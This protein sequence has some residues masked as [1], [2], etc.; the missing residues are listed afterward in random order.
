MAHVQ[1]LLNW[2][3]LVFHPYA[4]TLLKKHAKSSV[5]KYGF[6]IPTGNEQTARD[7]TVEYQLYEP[8]LRFTNLN[9]Y[10]FLI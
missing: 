1:I 3:I 2:L 4:G 5:V 9:N 8:G 7:E 10:S 6:A